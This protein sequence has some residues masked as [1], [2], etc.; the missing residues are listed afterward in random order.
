[1]PVLE[2]ADERYDLYAKRP[3]SVAFHD[4]V[5][6]QDLFVTQLAGDAHAFFAAVRSGQ[7]PAE[8]PTSSG[9][10]PLPAE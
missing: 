4:R 9:A 8:R 6:L 5:S 3:F 2:E 1:M 7:A 10:R